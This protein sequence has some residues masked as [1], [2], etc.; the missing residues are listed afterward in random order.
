[1]P[2]SSRPASVARAAV[3]TC[4]L[5]VLVAMALTAA[6]VG[7]GAVAP[8]G[9][10]AA[11]TGT[12]LL[13]DDFTHSTVTSTRYVAGGSG[14]GIGCLTATGPTN[15]NEPQQCADAYDTAG[16]GA[17]RLTRAMNNQTGFLLYDSAL[18]TSAGLDIEFR[19]YQW[20]GGGADGIAFF[21]AD[22]A[23]DLTQ[24]GPAGGSLGYQ[25]NGSRPGLPNALLGVGFD[26]W[27]NFVNEW[28]DRTTC[29]HGNYE[30]THSVSIRGPGHGYSGYCLLAGPAKVTGGLSAATRAA[31]EHDVR[32]V[33]DPPGHADPKVRVY[34]D[35]SLH[36]TGDQPA[37]FASTPTFKFGWAASTGGV[38]DN[39][40][41]RHLGVETVDPI[42]TYLGLDAPDLVTDLGG[43]IDVAAGVRVEALGGP[44]PANEPVTATFDAPADLS[45][46]G[47]PT[48]SGWSCTAPAAASSTCSYTSTESIPPDTDLPPITASFTPAGSGVSEIDIAVDTAQ[49]TA[50][51]EHTV[52][53]TLRPVARAVAGAGTAS[54]ESPETIEVDADADGSEPLVYELV[55]TPDVADGS[56]SIDPVT[57]TIGFTPAD[58]ASG[59]TT[60]S[61]RVTDTYDLVSEPATVT[62][63]TAPVATDLAADTDH[64]TAVDVPA[65]APVG[66]GPFSYQVESA[67]DPGHATATVVGSDLRVEPADGYS[68]TT[69]F[70]YRALDADGV[71][72]APAEVA[73]D[74]RPGGDADIS[75]ELA[76]DADGTDE[77]TTAAPAVSGDGPF[78][79][80]LDD[81]PEHGTA[82]I[83]EDT[84]AIT[85]LADGVSGS[86]TASDR[87]TDGH[88]LVSPAME[89][90]IVVRP[91]GAPIDATTDVDTELVV[92]AP[93]VHGTGPLSFTLDGVVDGT[94]SVDTD[95]RITFQAGSA[96]GSFV[97]TYE[98][99]D[100]DG[101][102]SGPV[103]VTIDVR[104]TVGDLA[105]TAAASGR[106]DPVR[107][108]VSPSGSGPYTVAIEAGPDGD[109]ATASVDG[110]DVVLTPT[111]DVSGRIELTYT[112]TGADDV[113]S[114][115]A[116]ATVTVAPV[117]ADTLAT[118]SSG[119]TA[120]VQLPAPRGTGPFTY[121]IVDSMAA[122]TGSA[123][124]DP[125]AGT[126]RLVGARDWSGEQTLTYVVYDGDGVVSERADIAASVTPSAYALTLPDTT[127]V[128]SGE[129][130]PGVAANVPTPAGTGPFTYQL[131]GGPV[132]LPG[133]ASID[134]STGKATFVPDAATSGTVRFT[135]RVVDANGL[136]S[137]D[138]VVLAQVRPAA[139]TSTRDGKDGSARPWTAKQGE[140]PLTF[141]LPTP[142]GDGPFTFR[143][144]SGP[145]VDQ[146]VLTLAPET[147]EVTFV[148]A[149]GFSGMVEFA[150]EVEDAD[151]LLSDAIGGT[152][153]V[154]AA[155][156]PVGSRTQLPFTGGDVEGLLT[157][158]LLMGVAG[159]FALRLGRRKPAGSNRS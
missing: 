147:G 35:G 7:I 78:T 96:S 102:G 67:P 84:G 16:D 117:A 1:M 92:P 150:Y 80:H 125:D 19:M 20:G 61:Y 110:M 15:G 119:R 155:A 62:I 11:G 22:G 26:A 53:A 77:A 134:A 43:D 32:I 136:A 103:P 82:T 73:V 37:E 90:P 56:A 94:A 25:S 89:V 57:G 115:P 8:E 49:A 55:T 71:A 126:L 3:S 63:T 135:Y 58:G 87:A 4:V 100:A 50:P 133:T 122:G 99:T 132:A 120:M 74:V 45:F 72:S 139:A 42:P 93:V 106:P 152:I 127:A 65:S 159:V 97:F 130:H 70:T 145:S 113:E 6:S 79:F 157:L 95:G 142:S 46:A 36:L 118:T 54:A 91:Y 27:G 10:S 52:Q 5:R 140:G 39:H 31:S 81:L 13:D 158:A 44:V 40:A 75:L 143:L 131:T 59:E 156:E 151:G 47:T 149:E 108:T 154:Q 114:L 85:Y 66:T 83:D 24:V 17:L 48:G 112:V 111:A 21:L 60:F 14:G 41:I 28:H 33:V 2:T 121:A 98:V 68:G 88:G 144:L 9:A 64:A 137:P 23:H 18:P 107:L 128:A 148:P 30:S 76:L 86:F 146:G 34:L 38:T 138:A 104:P 129:T 105:A 12:V 153:E 141:R 109:R 124:V 51:V 69:V 116:T 101:I 29:P 123:S